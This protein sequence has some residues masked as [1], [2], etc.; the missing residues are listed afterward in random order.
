M[1]GRPRRTL[2]AFG[3]VVAGLDRARVRFLL[4]RMGTGNLA[5][6]DGTVVRALYH[7]LFLPPDP[8]NALHAWQ[9][10]E[11]AGLELWAA[12]EPLGSPL[13]LW[14]AEHVVAGR[15]QVRATD[16]KGL[17]VDLTLF[18]DG[19]E[20]ESLWPARRVWVID[21]VEVPVAQARPASSD[22]AKAGA[23]SLLLP[24]PPSLR[25]ESSDDG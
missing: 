2:S 7:D 3:R 22:P 20:F 6:P 17:L 14:L 24:P 18:V 13:D 9:G 5:S 21:G 23:A 4:I 11:E 19:F 8:Q 15:V 25:G 16:R 12:G 1:D 10:C